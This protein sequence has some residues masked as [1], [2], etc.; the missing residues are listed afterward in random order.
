MATSN[1]LVN[2]GSNNTKCKHTTPIRKATHVYLFEN[3]PIEKT[4]SFDLELKPCINL[5]KHN[6]ANAIVLAVSVSPVDNP[7][8]KAIIVEIAIKIP[9]RII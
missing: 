2:E 1:I 3:T 6:V 9:S 5:D 8:W 4:D 7:I